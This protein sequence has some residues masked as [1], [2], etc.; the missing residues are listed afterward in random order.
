LGSA[1]VGLY[2]DSVNTELL[3]QLSDKWGVSDAAFI[4]GNGS[5]EIIQL[6]SLAF[7]NPGD[8]I[9]T[10]E[11]TFSEYAFGAALLDAKTITVKM[12]DF[13]YAVSDILSSVTDK[14][15]LIYIPNPNNP[16][17]TIITHDELA[18]LLEKVPSHCLVIVDEAYF[19]YVSDVTYPD[20][21]SLV[22]QY[23]NLMILRTFSKAYGLAAFRIGYGIADPSIIEVLH[24]VRQPF[25]VNGLALKAASIALTKTEFLDRTIAENE[26]GKTFFYQ[27]LEI[28]GLSFIPSH[29]NFVFIHLPCEASVVCDRLI[30]KGFAIRSMASFGYPNAIRVSTGTQDQTLVFFKVFSEIVKDVRN[31]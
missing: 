20:T 21:L 28:L 2:P 6:L 3:S 1:L 8:E 14:T 11:C 15:K 12:P 10:G 26:R 29:A 25:N 19:E 9:I 30:H 27:Q 17:G 7:L 13:R 4:L 23:S 16:T 24:K 22:S 31:E 18:F 5:D